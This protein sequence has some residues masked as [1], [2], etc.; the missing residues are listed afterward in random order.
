MLNHSANG[1]WRKRGESNAHGCYPQ[2]FSGPRPAPIGWRFHRRISN[3][4]DAYPREDSNLHM[5]QLRRLPLCPLSY[6]GLVG[7][8]GV[9]PRC[10]RCIRS[11]PSPAGSSPQAESAGFEPARIRTR[12]GIRTPNILILSQAPLPLGQPGYC[13]VTRDRTAPARLAK[14]RCAPAPTPREPAARLELAT[15]ALRERRTTGR[16][17]LAWSRRSDSNRPSPAY[18]AGAPRVAPRRHEAP[19]RGFEPRPT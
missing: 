3:L 16:A 19:R 15:S 12:R 13:G 10:Y 18:K 11:A 4:S 8:R 14:R 1:A 9:E 2:R 7:D 5:S 17:A 6:E